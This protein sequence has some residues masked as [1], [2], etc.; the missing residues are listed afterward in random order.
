MQNSSCLYLG[1]S[2]SQAVVNEH[3]TLGSSAVQPKESQDQVNTEQLK[4]QEVR[5]AQ[6]VWFIVYK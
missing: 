3:T 4:Q 6:K 1:M 5:Q 2:I